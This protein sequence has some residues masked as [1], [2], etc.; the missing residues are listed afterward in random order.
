MLR[1][2]LSRQRNL[3]LQVEFE[4]CR[5]SIGDVPVPNGGNLPQ[6]VAGERP[7]IP[8]ARRDPRYRSSRIH[9][10]SLQADGIKRSA[11]SKV[12]LPSVTEIF[13]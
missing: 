1:S 7:R 13:S 5:T 12:N 4:L 3:H 2:H 10:V 8:A 6:P 11:G 9:L